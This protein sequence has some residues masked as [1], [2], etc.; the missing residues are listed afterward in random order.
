MRYRVFGS[1][2][3]P[4]EPAAFLE[5]LHAGN[6][7]VTANFRGDDQGWFQAEIFFPEEDEPV[8]MDRFLSSE[9]GSRAELN[10][11]AAWLETLGDHPHRDLLMRHLIGTRQVFTLLQPPGED[12][13][14][15][16]LCLE[17]CAYLARETAGIYQVDGRG[18]FTEAGELL[19]SESA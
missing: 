11:W 10:T 7:P 15:I 3:S 14:L 19:V 2:D 12:E 9:Q 13:G 16:E 5:Y 17:V 18:F 1:N 6:L 4:V 8:K